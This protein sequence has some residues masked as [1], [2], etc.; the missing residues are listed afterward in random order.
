MSM[1]VQFD[2]EQ[3]KRSDTCSEL[4]S[5]LRRFRNFFSRIGSFTLKDIKRS[6][7]LNNET[8]RKDTKFRD[9][10]FLVA[11]RKEK[12]AVIAFAGKKWAEDHS[13]QC[14]FFPRENQKCP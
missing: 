7:V 12:D 1:F 10:S 6:G 11:T 9:A 4:S 3:F 5:L 14:F 8:F 13:R 2:L